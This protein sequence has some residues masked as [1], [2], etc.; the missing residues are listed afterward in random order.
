M[1]G[2]SR[3]GFISIPFKPFKRAGQELLGP[4]SEPEAQPQKQS[5]YQKWLNISRRLFLWGTGVGAA[6]VAGA[7]IVEKATNG[8]VSAALKSLWDDV[9]VRQVEAPLVDHF[10]DD[11]LNKVPSEQELLG[12]FSMLDR[13]L[14]FS[15]DEIDKVHW[16]VFGDSMNLVG[17][18][19]ADE[20]DPLGQTGSFPYQMQ[21]RV[22]DPHVKEDWNW[23][24]RN[25][26]IPGAESGN[27]TGQ[28]PDEVGTRDFLLGNRQLGNQALIAEMVRDEN[29]VSVVI[30]LNGDDWRNLIK[31]NAELEMYKAWI[32]NVKGLNQ[33]QIGKLKELADRHGTI[34]SEFGKNLRNALQ[35]LSDANI[36]RMGEGRSK[37]EVTF[38]LPINYRKAQFVPFQPK[39]EQSVTSAGL[40]IGDQDN[41]DNPTDL[42]KAL[43][44]ITMAI[45]GETGDSIDEYKDKYKDKSLS[46]H[47]VSKFGLEE[48]DQFI[49]TQ[50]P[51][52]GHLNQN[53]HNE[54][55]NRLFKIIRDTSVIPPIPMD[56]EPLIPFNIDPP[57]P[58][59]ATRQ[60]PR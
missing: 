22:N 55:A 10:V 29:P 51:S 30:S 56:Q 11:F 39:D 40:Q 13:E 6:T 19:R 50:G 33:D 36:E 9:F 4:S 25:Y 43:Y 3:R 41:P 20:F 21:H 34:T 2:R 54:I 5:R 12:N 26:S 57:E 7:L 59:L 32:Q 31:T 46:F 18:T 53:A 23:E 17:G 35:I 38:V 47:A 45:I 52:A 27:G 16:Y 28:F 8:G 37:I 1:T 24:G 44:H 58:V 48:S 14:E 15:R 42:Q 60:R 49:I